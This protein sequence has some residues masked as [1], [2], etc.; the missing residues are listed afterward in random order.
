MEA[1]PEEF[2]GDVP[3]M[4]PVVSSLKDIT[5]PAAGVESVAERTTVSP[6]AAL[7]GFDEPFAGFVTVNELIWV[8]VGIK[9]APVSTV[10][11][12]RQIEAPLTVAQLPVVVM[13][14]VAIL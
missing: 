13:F 8:V 5:S 10:P 1:V 6:I 3:M 9:E 2:V 14:K 7:A 12:F 4:N 11:V